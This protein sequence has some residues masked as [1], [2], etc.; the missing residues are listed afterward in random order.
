MR[1]FSTRVSK[2][3]TESIEAKKRSLPRLKNLIV[4]AAELMADTLCR[5]G[6]I[7][8]CGNGG[9]ACDA[10]HF[11]AELVNRFQLDRPPLAAIALN[12]DISTMTAIAND[13]G[14]DEIFSKQ[15]R[16]IGREGD[17]LLAISTSGNSLN[18]EMAVRAAKQKG[19]RVIMLSGKDGG[20]I[21]EIL[22]DNDIE[23][24]V[25]DDITS[26]IQEVHVLIVHCL[27]DLLEMQMFSSEE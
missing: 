9:S 2:T 22:D 13:F 7:L 11:A 6:K 26:R 16:A 19:M 25:Q 5:G 17:I 18:V 23:L 12:A 10:Q 4:R 8:T 20:K 27:C 21:A 3:F 15:V 1:N 14:Y 24:R